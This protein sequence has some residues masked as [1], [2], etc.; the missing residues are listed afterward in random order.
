MEAPSFSRGSRLAPSVALAAAAALLATLVLVLLPGFAAA[1]SKHGGHGGA[2]KSSSGLAKS[3]EYLPPKG[4]VFNG[5]SDTGQTSDYRD[6]QKQAAAHAAV[7]QSF[8][9]WGY[10]P[11]EAL[12]RWADTNTR[13]MLSLSTSPCYGCAEVI[14]PQSIAKGKGD[15]Y[16]LS[17]AK[18][19]AARSKPTY[20]RLFP[21]MNGFWNPYSAFH[22]GGESRDASHSTAQFKKAWRRFVLIVRGGERKAVNKQL[23]KLG[24]PAVKGKKSAKLPTPKVAFAWVPQTAGSPNIPGN[25]PQNYFPGWDY[26]DWVGTDMYGK[27]PNFAGLDGLYKK[28]SKA[29][30]LIGEWSTYDRDDPDFVKTLYG[31]IEHHGRARMAVYY[32]GFGEGPDNPYELSDFPKSTHALKLTLNKRMYEPFAPENED[33]GHKGGRGHKPNHHHGS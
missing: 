33:K 17:L 30:F 15:K 18:A 11:K 22:G 24:M 3:E 26:V 14:S 12:G 21:E 6:F 4:K 13:G 32:Q 29:P 5:V 19:L 10:V 25:Q 7:M 27:F 2:K 16:M 9:S 1:G 31:W 23:H 28:Y 8:E 20:I